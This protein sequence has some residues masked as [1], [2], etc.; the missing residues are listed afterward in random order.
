MSRAMGMSLV[1]R[2]PS[3]GNGMNVAWSSSWSRRHISFGSMDKIVGQFA[4]DTFIESMSLNS[5]AIVSYLTIE[6]AHEKRAYANFLFNIRTHR[7]CQLATP[8]NWIAGNGPLVL[9]SE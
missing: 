3:H 6:S 1:A 9:I 8:P 4:A 5:K 2:A 7:L